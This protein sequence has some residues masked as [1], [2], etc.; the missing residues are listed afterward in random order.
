MTNALGTVI[1]HESVCSQS[2]TQNTGEAQ[3]VSCLSVLLFSMGRTQGLV[4]RSTLSASLWQ[5]GLAD[6]PI[7]PSRV[8][9][10]LQPLPPGPLFLKVLQSACSSFGSQHPESRQQPTAQLTPAPEP[11]DP[12]NLTTF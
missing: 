7:A 4:G 1:L 12:A 9:A 6:R 10:L 3:R 2:M 5:R 11:F 8:P